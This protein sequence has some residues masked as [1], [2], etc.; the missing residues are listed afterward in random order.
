[1]TSQQCL[2]VY[3]TSSTNPRLMGANSSGRISSGLTVPKLAGKVGT[4]DNE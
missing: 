1:M 2:L 4:K 3:A